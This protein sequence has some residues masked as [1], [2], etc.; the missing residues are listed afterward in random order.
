M[1]AAAAALAGAALFVGGVLSGA[2]PG[3]GAPLIW[4]RTIAMHRAAA[5]APPGA[6]APPAAVVADRPV[7]RVARPVARLRIASYAA[8]PGPAP[9]VTVVPGADATGADRHRHGRH[10]D[11]RRERGRYR[12]HPR[13]D[14]R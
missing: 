2:W 9:A 10:G 7:R 13:R 12:V 4:V 5:P 8:P 3:R 1:K 11:A 14:G 6:A